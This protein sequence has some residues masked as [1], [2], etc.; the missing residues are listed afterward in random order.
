MADPRCLELFSQLSE[1]LDGDLDPGICAEI[2][3]HLAD[4]LP[5]AD[6]MATLRRTVDLCHALPPAELPDDLRREVRA[7]LDQIIGR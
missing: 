6:V 1:Y 7:F 2:E 5:C 3:R 4:C